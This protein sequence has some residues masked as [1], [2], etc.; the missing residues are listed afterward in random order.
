MKNGV[1]MIIHIY[2]KV[3]NKVDVWFQDETKIGQQGSITRIW[4]E[5]GTY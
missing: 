1:L 5:K 2:A 4:A 3:S